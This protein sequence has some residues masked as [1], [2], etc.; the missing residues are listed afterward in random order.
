MEIPRQRLRIRARTS[1][2]PLVP[3]PRYTNPYPIPA[4]TAPYREF[5][6]RS[7]VMPS[8]GRK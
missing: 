4:T 7:G 8:V 1:L 5:N 6:T 2:P 3:C